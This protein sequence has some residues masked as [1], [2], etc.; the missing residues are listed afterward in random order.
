LQKYYNLDAAEAENIVCN[1]KYIR[2]NAKSVLANNTEL[3]KISPAKLF[4]TIQRKREKF[5]C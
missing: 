2:N 3:H 5:R 1:E 4:D